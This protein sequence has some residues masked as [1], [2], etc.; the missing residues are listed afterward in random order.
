MIIMLI[1]N[2]G[3]Q[4]F[5]YYVQSNHNN[6]GLCSTITYNEKQFIIKYWTKFFKDNGILAFTLCCCGR[7]AVKRVRVSL[8]LEPYIYD[9]LY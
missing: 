5:L 1:Q 7:F 3:V 9:K 2:L 6:F 4:L 8:E